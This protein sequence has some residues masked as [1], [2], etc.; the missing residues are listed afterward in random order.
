MYRLAA[1]RPDLASATLA[2]R[3]IFLGGAQVLI[4]V[5]AVL[6]CTTRSRYLG[7]D[8]MGCAIYVHLQIEARCPGGPENG[9]ASQP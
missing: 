7:R 6:L 2:G 4:S 3:Q 9:P 1:C 8:G 5:D